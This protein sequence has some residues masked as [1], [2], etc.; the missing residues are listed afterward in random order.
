M[1]LTSIPNIQT[2]DDYRDR[3][4]LDLI[5]AERELRLL[6][7]S[8]AAQM[9]KL[10]HTLAFRLAGAAMEDIRKTNP[11][12]PD[13]WKAEDWSRFFNQHVITSAAP[14]SGWNDSVSLLSLQTE[15]QTL[16][17][18][19]EAEKGRASQ[20]VKDLQSR[21]AEIANRDQTI[22]GLQHAMAQ[23]RADLMQSQALLEQLQSDGSEDAAAQVG[24]LLTETPVGM[25]QFI[26]PATTTTQP[27]GQGI[28]L[29]VSRHPSQGAKEKPQLMPKPEENR[30]KYAGPAFVEEARFQQ[31]VQTLTN[32]QTPRCPERY[33]SRLEVDGASETRARRHSMI[34][35]LVARYGLSTNLEIDRVIATAEK[36]R[37]RSN[38]VKTPLAE[39]VKTGFLVQ[40]TLV[41]KE[42]FTTSLVCLRLSEDGKNLCRI[43]GWEPVEGDWERVIRLHQGDRPE[44]RDHTMG[45][46]I[47][48]MHARFR[49]WSVEILPDVPGP[50]RPDLAVMKKGELYFVEF[51][52]SSNGSKDQKWRNISALH[53]HHKVGICTYTA[54]GRTRHANDCSLL[55]IG[56]VAAD[57]ASLIFDPN[58]NK[59]LPIDEISSEHDLWQHCW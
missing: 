43:W 11:G 36:V 48:S 12:A 10:L 39:L 23:Y 2:G 8:G 53:P 49:G 27:I 35:Y 4:L 38:S 28:T 31:M 32:W 5:N 57:L 46:L 30:S 16:R 22:T 26:Q 18:Q 58:T 54:E 37:M 3:A 19:A 44:N 55:R 21:D 50:A 47:L 33:R 7:E 51:E 40:E 14:N 17:D 34:L 29:S 15:I 24:D 20:L 56:G 1:A 25:N 13:N 45:I 42:P 9:R 41:L 59:P 6:A 52:N